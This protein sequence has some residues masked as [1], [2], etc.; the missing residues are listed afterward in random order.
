[1]VLSIVSDWIDG[2][3][4]GTT[5]PGQSEPGSNGIEA[6]STLSKHQEWKFTIG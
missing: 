3:L 6:Y 1:M 5:T 2:T 4:T